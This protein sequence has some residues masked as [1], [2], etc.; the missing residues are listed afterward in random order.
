L[1]GRSRLD[2]RLIL[3]LIF[4]KLTSCI[5]WYDLPIL[6]SGPSWQTC[7]QRY[8]RWQHSRIWNSLIHT[9]YTDLH[10]RSG[11]DL[12]A[13]IQNKEIS[14]YKGCSCTLEITLPDHLIGTW[15]ASTATLLIHLLFG[16]L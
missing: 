1:R 8:Q 13:S 16:E 9:L 10:A 14:I 3:E 2:N 5:P 11:L 15:Q 4:R 6:P 12:L 7:C